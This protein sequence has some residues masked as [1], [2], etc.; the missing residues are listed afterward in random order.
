M[1]SSVATTLL[2]GISP[3]ATTIEDSSSGEVI[4]VFCKSDGKPGSAVV[5]AAAANSAD[6][7][8]LIPQSPKTKR[9]EHHAESD[10]RSHP[11]SCRILFSFGLQPSQH[12]PLGPQFVA[13]MRSKA[14]STTAL[15]N[16]LHTAIG[17][18]KLGIPS[19]LPYTSCEPTY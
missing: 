15:E 14:I 13:T 5:L 1:V 11:C 8:R 2:S 7:G 6:E 9:H 4:I 19:A 17:R 3:P 12:C 10:T 16:L 18:R